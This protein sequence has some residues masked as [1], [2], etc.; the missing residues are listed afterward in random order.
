MEFGISIKTYLPAYQ[1]TFCL[2]I[3]ITRTIMSEETDTSMAVH[4]QPSLPLPRSDSEST[5]AAS[6]EH[7]SPN[8]PRSKPTSHSQHKEAYDPNLDVNLPYRTL[9]Q[10]ANFNEFSS[11]ESSGALPTTSDGAG[12]LGG[13]QPSEDSSNEKSRHELVTFLPNDKENPKNWS[14]MY[15]WY[16]TMVV[17]V[18]CFVVA[19]NSSVVTADIIGV[20][21]ELNVSEEV[22]LLSISLFV[23]GFGIGTTVSSDF[24]RSYT[25]NKQVQW[26]LHLS[27]RLLAEK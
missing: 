18:T 25:N 10:N 17:A 26:H 5:I 13:I 2:I 27:Q 3:V 22:V 23:V 19:F 21:D 20:V 16:C 8:K 15:K 7:I 1:Y 6:A 4:S 24:L 14:L 12:R 9:T 11:E